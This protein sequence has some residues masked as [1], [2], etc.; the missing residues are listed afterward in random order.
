MEVV[1]RNHILPHFW[2]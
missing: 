2:T 1:I